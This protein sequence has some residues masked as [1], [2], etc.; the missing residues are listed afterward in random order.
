VL[1]EGRRIAVGTAAEVAEDPAVREAYLGRRAIVREGSV[2]PGV[3]PPG[4]TPT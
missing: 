4:A 3:P 2:A 1:N